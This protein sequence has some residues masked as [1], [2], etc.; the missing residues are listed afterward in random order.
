MSYTTSNTLG[1]PEQL[2][3]SLYQTVWHGMIHIV[4]VSG[5]VLE[6]KKRSKLG[7]LII[8][9]GPPIETPQDSKE[10]PFNEEIKQQLIKMMQSCWVELVQYKTE[11]PF[12][13]KWRSL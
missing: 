1:G 7:K 11:N 13:Q 3:T 12:D 4:N 2:Q 9:E 6:Q 10:F 5:I 8:I